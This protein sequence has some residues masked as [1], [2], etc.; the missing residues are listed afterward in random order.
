MFVL[1]HYKCVPS[2]FWEVCFPLCGDVFMFCFQLRIINKHM[3]RTFTYL[4]ESKWSEKE[5]SYNFYGDKKKEFAMLHTRS[6][7][8]LVCL[9]ASLKKPKPVND[10][11]CDLCKEVA[12]QLINMVKDK[13]TEVRLFSSQQQITVRKCKIQC[14]F[15]ECL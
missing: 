8:F 9:P 10:M 13:R 6:L 5:D 2:C 7:M 14:D 1:G 3:Y 4:S 12:T 11:E 15:F